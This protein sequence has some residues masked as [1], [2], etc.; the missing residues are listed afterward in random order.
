MGIRTD[1]G[2][3]KNVEY[4]ARG[5]PKLRPWPVKRVIKPEV[6]EIKS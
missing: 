1:N 2:R 5:T 3:I 4:K 6:E